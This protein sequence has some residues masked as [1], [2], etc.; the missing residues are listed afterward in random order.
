MAQDKTKKLQ[1]V[2]LKDTNTAKVSAYLL[3]MA[4]NGDIT[5]IAGVAKRGPHRHKLFMT[6][7][8]R[9]SPDSA[10]LALECLNDLRREI[11]LEIMQV[12]EVI[13]HDYEPNNPNPEIP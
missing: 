10:R 8:Y 5:A 9:E 2:R 11:E 7:D 13:I 4:V 1:V 3:G 12:E 6:G